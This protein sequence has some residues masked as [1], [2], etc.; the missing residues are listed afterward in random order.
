MGRLCVF[1]GWN[2]GIDNYSLVTLLRAQC[3][4]I[5]ALEFPHSRGYSFVHVCTEICGLKPNT[6]F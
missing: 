1:G 2:V 5:G 3:L 6:E 4:T